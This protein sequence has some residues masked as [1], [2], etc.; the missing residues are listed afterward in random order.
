M[1]RAQFTAL[2]TIV[3]VAGLLRADMAAPPSIPERVAAADVIVVGKV[4][5]FGDKLVS[6]KPPWGGEKADYQIANVKILEVFQGAKDA[7]EIKV[8]F[9]PPPSGAAPGKSIRRPQFVLGLEQEV[10]LFVHPHGDADFFAGDYYYN[11]VPKKDN[12]QFEKDV[13]QVKRCAKL[14]DDPTASLKG[15]NADDRFL[16]AA[17]LLTRYRSPRPG[18][19][20]A[21]KTEAIDADESKLI[22]QALAEADWDPAKAPGFQLNPQALFLRLGLTD[23]D[24]WTPPKDFAKFGAAAKRWLEDNAEKYRVQRF[25]AEKKDK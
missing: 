1:Q 7:K 16:T 6:A 15:K 21:P 4:T 13:D 25:I 2:A 24:G 17:M 3:A 9:V 5:G 19:G 10:L 11:V 8:G 18:A 20:A 14:L 12:P 22:L 23:K